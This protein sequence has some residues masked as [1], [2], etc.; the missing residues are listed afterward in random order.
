MENPSDVR[1]LSVVIPTYNRRIRLAALLDSL[2]AQTLQAELLEVIVVDDGSTDDTAALAVRTYPFD[3]TYLHQA[4]QGD[5]AARNTGAAHAGGE[6]ILFL[7]DDIVLHPRYLE[8]ILPGLSIGPDRIVVGRDIPWLTEATPPLEPGDEQANV[9]RGP[10]LRPIPF[11]EV[12]SN[13]MAIRREGFFRVGGMDSLGFQG[14]SIWCDVEFCY[15]A[16]LKGFDFFRDEHAVCWHL[17]HVLA[18][19]ESRRRRARES[20]IRA[21][22]L[23]DRHPALL[24]HLPMFTDKIPV[25]VQRDPPRLILR[26]LFRRLSAA[27]AGVGLMEWAVRRMPPGLTGAAPERALQR[28]LV[29]AEIYRGYHRG[30]NEIGSRAERKQP[31]RS[32]N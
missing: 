27:S 2:V 6:F 18:S 16:Y 14:S 23:I 32:R 28:W 11:A 22:S 13:N 7:D 20:G 15:R 8:C 3:F 29:G 24:E 21:A 25:D 5:A 17:D 9:R 4:N 19:L 31:G 10:S 30:L 1:V 12:C 26:K